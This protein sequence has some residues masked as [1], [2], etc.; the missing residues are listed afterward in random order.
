MA[1]DRNGIRLAGGEQ[2]PTPGAAPEDALKQML[3]TLVQ[4]VLEQEFTR[5]VGAAPHERTRERRGWRNGRRERRFRTR[6]GTLVLRVP[7]DRAGQF[8]PSLF[9]RYQRSEQAFVLALTEMYVQGVSTRK[10]TH[11]VEELCGTRVSA[12]EVSALVKKLDTELAAWRSRSLEGEAFPYLVIDAHEEQ[13]RREGH[14][15][16]TAML[17]VIGISE[18]GYRQH[19]GCWL[20]ASE[21]QESWTMVFEDLVRRGLRG[22]RYAVSDDH[23]G[24]VAALRR[25]FPDAAHQR[26]QVHYLRNALSKISS[27]GQQRALLAALRDVWNAPTRSEADSRLARLIAKL[28]KP[29]PTVATWLEESAAATL[30]V[31]ELPSPELRRR[32]RTT[33]SIEH[34]HAEIRRRTRVIRIFP[35]EASLLRLGTALAIER[36]EHWLERRYFTPNPEAVPLVQGQIRLRR[37]G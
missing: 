9:A 4:Q 6:V 11:I 1:F 17:W 22:V 31:F 20:G 16:G 30:M 26:C 34:D 23:Q 33:N 13:V 10:V 5:F 32:L 29:L 8:Q 37:T 35:N 14:V 36:N 19:L 28:R 7:R 18:S 27:P 21:S 15:R 25:F 24:L 12:S 2:G 3:T